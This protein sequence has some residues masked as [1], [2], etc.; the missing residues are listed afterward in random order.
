VL[1]T[2]ITRPVIGAILPN[3]GDGGDVDVVLLS[4]APPYVGSAPLQAL[5]SLLKQSPPLV[6]YNV[7]YV[8][9]NVPIIKIQQDDESLD[10]LWLPGCKLDVTKARI[11]DNDGSSSTVNTSSDDQGHTIIHASGKH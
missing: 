4:N 9:A 7:W 8:T 3:G 11:E 10:L 5:V 1:C 2:D 6:S